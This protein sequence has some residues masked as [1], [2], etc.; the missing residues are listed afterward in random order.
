[1]RDG[2]KKERLGLGCCPLSLAAM[3]GHLL[4][5]LPPL[6]LSLSTRTPEDPNDHT[7]ARKRV[8]QQ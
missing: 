3:R 1:M 5:L 4:L 6:A 2:G 7:Q 8:K